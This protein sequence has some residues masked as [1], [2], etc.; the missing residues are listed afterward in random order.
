HVEPGRQEALLLL[1]AQARVAEQVAVGRHP[2]DG[3]RGE[4]V[5]AVRARGAAQQQVVGVG[6]GPGSLPGGGGAGRRAGGAPGGAGVGVGRGGGGRGGGGGLGGG[7]VASGGGGRFSPS[8]VPRRGRP[9]KENRG[10]LCRIAA[11]PP[12]PPARGGT[13]RLRRSA[14]RAREPP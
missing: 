4:A 7:G 5:P 8:A 6:H 10:G 13:P 12:V 2:Q 1:G 11:G 3:L 14:S 9:R